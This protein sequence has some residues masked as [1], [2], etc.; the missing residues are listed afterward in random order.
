MRCSDSAAR[1][2]AVILVD[3]SAWI[4]LLRPKGDPVVRERVERVLEAGEACWCPMVRLELWNGAGG[5]R[6]KKVLR[7]FERV[8]P[9][10]SFDGAVWEG[11][12][13][14]ARRARA[15]GISIPATDLVIAACAH[16]HDVEL[17]HADS[18]F[19]QLASL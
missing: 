16:R 5:E 13:D 9:E 17:E 1:V 6:E 4:H 19:E 12:F 11:A 18:D 15:A 2:N 14:L 3:T 7:D 8:L 10:L